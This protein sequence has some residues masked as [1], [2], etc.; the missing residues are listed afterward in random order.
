METP[1]SSSTTPTDEAPQDTNGVSLP[2]PRVS[3]FA[4]VKLTI[5]LISALATTIL[6]GAWCPQEAAVGREKVFETFPADMANFLISIGMSDVFHSPFFLFLIAMLTVNMVACSFQRVFPKIKTMKA[7]M[8]FLHGEQI[9]RMPYAKATRTAGPSTESLGRLA[10]ELSRRRFKVDMVGERLTAEYG[11]YGRLAATVTHIGLLTLLLG[12]TITSWTGFSGF[13]PVRL[14]ETM[15]FAD[16]QH[17]KLWIGSLP[18]WNV[19]VRS[20]RRENHPTGEAKQWY[21][22]LQVVGPHGEKLKRGEISVNNPLS[23]DGVDIYQSTWGLDQV[24]VSFNGHVKNL[25]LTPMG[26][27]YAAMMPLDRDSIMIFSV[28][29]QSSPLRLFAKRTDWQAPKP[30]G[31]IKPNHSVDLGGVKLKFI[32]VVP[33]TGLQYKCD[34]GIPIVYPAFAL[35]II[36]VSMAMIPHRQ[37]WASVSNGTLH[38]GGRS[39]KARVGFERLM[40]KILA[41]ISPV[42]ET[43]E[44]SAGPDEHIKENTTTEEERVLASSTTGNQ[45]DV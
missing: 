42:D 43:V 11:K 24:R 4:S 40:D 26:K 38:V 30:L 12:V 8:P 18:K 29:D 39:V 16:S 9:M 13:T 27:R 6:A 44:P 1:A 20:T 31:E 34:P 35:I 5:I 14:G 37:V 22:D 33:I 3:F 21:S 15:S 36:G 19:E 2:K 32:G 7:K 10:V 45:A 41:T 25:T 23:Y 28:M 17:S